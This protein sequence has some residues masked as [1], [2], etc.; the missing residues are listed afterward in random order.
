M[1]TKG[2][3]TAVSGAM[4]Q[5][6]RMDTIANNIA[7]V[8]TPSFKKDGQL[9]R[10]Y[11]TSYEKLNDVIEAP[12]DPASIESFY[13]MNGG[14]KS[15][16]DNIGTFTDFSQGTLK[17]TGNPLDIAIEGKGFF[18]VLTPQGV[19]FTRNGMFHHDAEGRIVTKDGYPVLTSGTQAPQDRVLRAP[20]EGQLLIGRNGEVSKNEQALG[21][22][23]V[24]TVKNPDA[25]QKVGNSLY[26]L[27]DNIAPQTGP[28]LE[29][30]VHQGSVEM[31]NVNI[32]QEMT[33]MIGATRVFESTQKAIQAYDQMNDKLINTV[34]KF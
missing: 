28:A 17:L 1:S 11:L 6:A 25:F 26:K 12:R 30:S 2:I 29:Y 5:S 7:N 21:T 14:D 24:V 33:D 13:N 9:F 3:F 22:L 15:Y 19:R 23:A 20:F 16:A 10:E 4:A 8:N 27:R 31:S 32:I 34:P 18:E